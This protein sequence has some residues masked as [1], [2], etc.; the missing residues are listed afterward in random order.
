MSLMDQNH[1]QKQHF[2]HNTVY[3]NLP[4]TYC[5]CNTLCGTHTYIEGKLLLYV[6]RFNQLA[7]SLLAAIHIEF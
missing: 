6:Q 2:E 5:I 3:I 4:D 1:H 7:A